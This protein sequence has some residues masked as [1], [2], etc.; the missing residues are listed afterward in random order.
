M[1]EELDSLLRE[2]HELET[3]A[4]NHNEDFD[5]VGFEE[6]YKK[7]KELKLKISNELD[8]IQSLKS[9]LETWKQSSEDFR[10]ELVLEHKVV[11][12]LNSKNEKLQK[13]TDEIRKKLSSEDGYE[14]SELKSILSNLE[15]ITSEIKS[16]E[17]TK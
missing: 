6:R 17:E 14:T 12:E 7:H 3:I 13:V 15:P 5:W 9:Q 1:T 16:C 8:E 2:H 11:L 4:E 10:K